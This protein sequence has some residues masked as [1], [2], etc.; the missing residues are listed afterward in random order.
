MSRELD[1]QS[2]AMQR[3]ALIDSK[4]PDCG[5]TIINRG[6]HAERCTGIQPVI[7]V[8][9]AIAAEHPFTDRDAIRVARAYLD[10]VMPP[11]E[12]T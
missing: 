5:D 2:I 9:I 3:A 6:A 1:L 4:C 11:R 12:T 8:A 7:D 10:T